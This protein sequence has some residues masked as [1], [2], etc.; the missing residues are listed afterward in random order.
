MAAGLRR[1]R[2]SLVRDDAPRPEGQMFNV[3]TYNIHSAVGID[4][5]FDPE[6]IVRV[7]RR[8]EAAVIALQEVGWHHRG[9]R[10]FNQFAF[11]ARELGMTCIEGPTKHHA[12]AH[13]G[14]AVLT[15]LAVRRSAV[16][17]LTVPLE[18]PRGAIIAELDGPA[19]P[20]TLINMHLGLTAIHRRAQLRR[21]LPHLAGWRPP[22]VICGDYNSW[23]LTARTQ[24]LLARLAPDATRL[25]SFRAPYARIPIDR[26]QVSPE[27]RL[28]TAWRPEDRD[29]LLASDHLPVVARI[30]AR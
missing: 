15:T 30:A 19:G 24:R 27:F 29:T 9:E 11:Y 5:R 26:V 28:I 2:C 14:N 23:K 6:R 3:V 21:L 20:F 8:C 25:P 13:F 7:L 16:V 18:L 17:D 12:H 10:H 1:L 4:R 22:Y